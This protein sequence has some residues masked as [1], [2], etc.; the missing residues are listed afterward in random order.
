MS[1]FFSF[2]K[3]FDRLHG[4]LSG[5][6]GAQS[7]RFDA[8][9][10]KAGRPLRLG[11]YVKATGQQWTTLENLRLTSRNSIKFEELGRIGMGIE[12]HFAIGQP[13]LFL[14]SQKA[15]ILWDC[16]PLPHEAVVEAI[17]AMRGISAIAHPHYYSSMGE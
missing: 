13:A 7:T 3:W 14:R 4:P 16:L 5:L 9:L 8:R 15:N 10:L 2:R 6:G 1:P 17:K 12:P 11:Q